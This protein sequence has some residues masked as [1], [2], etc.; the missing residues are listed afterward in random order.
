MDNHA[1]PALLP[2]YRRYDLAFARGEGAW[3]YTTDGRRM[4]DF[5]SGIAVTGLGHAHPH[6]L[7]TI[8]E[9]AGKLWHV[10][11]LFQIPELE[12]LADR[13]V[14]HT[15]A[16]TV[17]VCNSGAEAIEGCIKI[18]RRYHWAR[19]NPERNR[20]ITFEGAFHGRTMAGISAAGSKKMVE[21]FDPLL[22]G[23]DIVPFNDREALHAAIGEATGASLI[24]PIQGEGG[25]REVPPAFLQ[26]L[27]ALCDEHG[28]L[29]ILDEI[30]TGMGRTGTLLVCEQAGVRPDIAALA[31]GLGGGFPVGACLATAEAASGMTPGSHGSTYGG[32]PLAMAVGV[33]SVE[34]LVKPELLAHVREVAGYI[35]PVPGGVGP[36]TVTMLLHNTLAAARQQ[37]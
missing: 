2:V 1:I 22:P 16:D 17:F 21:G 12:R 6:L 33:A 25:I 30:Q 15:F 31:K 27:R 29:L 23:F 36:L 13:L 32:N 8:A 14:A 3:L 34:E 19:G 37:Q 4:L 11:N 26:E 18:A 20:I 10:S 5:A 35:S 24:E 7:G 9:Q 28:L